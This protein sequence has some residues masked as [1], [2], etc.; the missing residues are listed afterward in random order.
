MRPSRTE[1]V[2][3]TLP[4]VTGQVPGLALELK[5]LQHLGERDDAEVAAEPFGML[6]HR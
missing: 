4:L 6:G 2:T 1:M 3:S 5:H